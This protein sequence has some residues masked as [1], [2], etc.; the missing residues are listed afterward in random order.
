M[1]KAEKGQNAGG[2]LSH[3]K[4]RQGQYKHS[5]LHEPPIIDEPETSRAAAVAIGKLF[6]PPAFGD[7]APLLLRVGTIFVQMT[8]HRV[9]HRNAKHARCESGG[10]KSPQRLR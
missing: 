9:L 10:A 2:S 5:G 1:I 3:D 7:L 8:K 4:R 6:P